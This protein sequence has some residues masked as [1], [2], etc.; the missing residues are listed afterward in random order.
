MEKPVQELPDWVIH[1]FGW[2]CVE[3]WQFA[4]AVS[5]RRGNTTEARSFGLTLEGRLETRQRKEF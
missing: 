1:V 2:E 3:G 5:A 4:G